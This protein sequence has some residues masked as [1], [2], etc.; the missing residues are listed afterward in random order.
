MAGGINIKEEYSKLT[1]AQQR[2]YLE[3]RD[4]FNKNKITVD[5]LFDLCTRVA[6][7]QREVGYKW[8]CSEDQPEC[9]II[10]ITKGD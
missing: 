2:A 8:E 3:N 7:M 9:P 5:F 1:V 4:A 10:F 6:E